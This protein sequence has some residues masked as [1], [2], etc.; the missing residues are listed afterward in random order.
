MERFPAE[1]MFLKVVETGSFAEAA[2]QLRSSSGQASKL[3]ARLEADLG[4]KLLNRSTRA[5]ALTEAGQAY[6]ER[7]RGLVDAFDDLDAEMHEAAISPRGLLRLT[8]PLSLGTIRLAPMLAEFARAYPEIALDV[9]FT[10][11]IVSL[12]DEGFDAAIR[13]GEPTDTALTG[14]R[15]GRVKTLA[16]ASPGYLAERGEPQRP[17]DL[18]AHDCVID[19]NRREPTKWTFPGG[20][21][22][23]VRGRLYL[24]NASA[25]VAAAEAGLGIAYVPDFVA[26]EAVATGAVRV[27]LAAH[28]V[29]PLPVSVLYPGGRHVPAKLRV[30]IDFLVRAFRESG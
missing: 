6:A 1:R 8:A 14:R 20:E 27:V 18:V 13:V 10:D 24:S 11:R 28:Q 21:R 2:R 25:C 4:V 7:L 23:T 22:V 5:L 30:L 12:M 26:T 3:V 16:L 29:E 15:L 17:A 19:T 9:Q